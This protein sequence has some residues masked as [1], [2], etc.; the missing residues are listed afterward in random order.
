MLFLGSMGDASFFEEA[1]ALGERPRIRRTGLV[2][3]DEVEGLPAIYMSEFDLRVRRNRSKIEVKI[4]PVKR[5]RPNQTSIT[6]QH[7][8][9]TYLIALRCEAESKLK[10]FSFFSSFPREGPRPPELLLLLLS[11]EFPLS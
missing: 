3:E 10:H 7:Y 11:S 1:L 2:G 9:Q 5:A 6:K 4:L 8:H